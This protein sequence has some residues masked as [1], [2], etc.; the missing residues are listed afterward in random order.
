MEEIESG[1]A[2]YQTDHKISDILNKFLFNEND[3]HDNGAD[4]SVIIN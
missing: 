4:V 2:L 3:Q 1:R